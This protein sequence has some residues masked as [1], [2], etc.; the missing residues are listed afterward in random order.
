MRGLDLYIEIGAKCYKMRKL[1]QS[2]NLIAVILNVTQSQ[3]RSAFVWF[4]QR[5]FAIKEKQLKN[6]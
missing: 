6:K 3:A 2:F 4:A 1:G 5:P